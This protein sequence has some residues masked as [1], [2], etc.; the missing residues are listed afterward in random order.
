MRRNIVR[1]CLRNQGKKDEFSVVVVIVVI[2]PTVVTIPTVGTTG[3]GC[4]GFVFMY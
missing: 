2:I 3:Y 1:Y 4:D